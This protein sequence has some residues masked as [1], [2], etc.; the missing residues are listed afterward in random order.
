MRYKTTKPSNNFTKI[1]KE[2]VINNLSNKFENILAFLIQIRIFTPDKRSIK[3]I[4]SE[5]TICLTGKMPTI[6]SWR[7]G[8]PRQ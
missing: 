6:F 3:N 5:T 8:P 7:L 1:A 4:L 2:K